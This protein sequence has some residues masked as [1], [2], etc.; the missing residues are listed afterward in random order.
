M[1]IH[2]FDPKPVWD[3][4]LSHRKDDE[5]KDEKELEREIEDLKDKCY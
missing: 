2:T 5:G 1:L 3:H 4:V